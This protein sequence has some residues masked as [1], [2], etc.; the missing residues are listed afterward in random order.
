[1]LTVFPILKSVSFLRKG[2]RSIVDSFVDC[3]AFFS[4]IAPYSSW[5]ITMTFR[6]RWRY[7]C[8]P[9]GYGISLSLSSTEY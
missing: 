8:F 9:I 3:V 6:V 2:K 5:V 7:G 1:M 4:G